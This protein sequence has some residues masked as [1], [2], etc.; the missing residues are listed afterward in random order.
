MVAGGWGGPSLKLDIK[1]MRKKERVMD[2][3]RERM[4]KDVAV[5]VMLEMEMM[6]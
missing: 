1:Y 5:A 3:W 2:G 4:E 6:D